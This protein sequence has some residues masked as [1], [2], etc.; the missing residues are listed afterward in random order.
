M[1]FYSSV[2]FADND[3]RLAVV[4]LQQA[5]AESTAGKKAQE[6]YQHD[7]LEAQKNIDLKKKEFEK[8][9]EALKS[10]KDSLNEKALLSKSEEL[11]TVERDLQRAFKDS[12]EMLQRKNATIVNELVKNIRE[13]IE[14]IGKEQKLS[15]ILEKGSQALLFSEGAKDIT[16]E[17]VERFNARK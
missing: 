12:Q 16:T 13:V 7:V 8:K 2:A 5:L 17:V 3:L 15:L 11:M 4:D 6:E 14:G 1:L 9:R 10:Q